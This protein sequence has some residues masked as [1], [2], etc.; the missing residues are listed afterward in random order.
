MSCMARAF[1]MNIT[2]IHGETHSRMCYALFYL[3]F[4]Y[5]FATFGRMC[6]LLYEL[7]HWIELFLL[8]TCV[9]RNITK[10]KKKQTHEP[11]C[12]HF[13]YLRCCLIHLTQFRNQNDGFLTKGVLG[14]GAVIQ[15]SFS[16]MVLD[17]GYSMLSGDTS[18]TLTY[19]RKGAT[20][21]NC[22][23]H[24]HTLAIYTV[25]IITTGSSLLSIQS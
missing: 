20:K 16:K 25:I 18:L 19:C 2:W 8:V 4:Y 7:H 21:N 23:P 12:S 13:S 22:A 1:R 5:S 11:I 3:A 14:F 24:A 15:T 9:T 10:E 17:P 6:Q